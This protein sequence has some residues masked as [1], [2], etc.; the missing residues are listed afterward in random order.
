MLTGTFRSEL[1]FFDAS[2]L[3]SKEREKTYVKHRRVKHLCLAATLQEPA[4]NTR[5]HEAS[6]ISGNWM[7]AHSAAWLQV[8]IARRSNVNQPLHCL[9]TEY[10]EA[11]PARRPTEREDGVLLKGRA[12]W[13]LGV[14]EHSTC[15]S[16]KQNHSC[17]PFNTVGRCAW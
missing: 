7:L 9:T 3:R 10:E 2:S 4:H 8:R 15:H 12:S 13:H 17:S 14:M 6:R 11:K 1:L 5:Q 16:S